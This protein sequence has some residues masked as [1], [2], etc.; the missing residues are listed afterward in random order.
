MTPAL[1]RCLGRDADVPEDVREYF[2][3]AAALNARRNELMQR[4]LARVVGLLNA[5][6]IEPMPLKGAAHLAEGLYPEPSLRLLGDVDILIP[7]NRGADAEAALKAGESKSPAGPPT[8]SPATASSSAD[9]AQ[10]SRNRDWR[11]TAH[12]RH[13]PIARRRDRHGLVPAI[14]AAGGIPRSAHS[15]SRTD[16][17]CRA[18]HFSQR[19]LPRA[20]CAEEGSVAPSSRSGSHT[21]AARE[22]NRLGHAR[23]SLLGGGPGRGA[24]YLSRLRRRTVRPAGTEA[25]PRSP[26]E[27]HGGHARR[28]N[29]ATV[30]TSRSRP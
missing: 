16:P 19:D 22:R 6:D 12:R 13:Q 11:R 8:S 7:S 29:R 2:E 25:E 18:Q 21:S 30:S 24:R 3:A 14:R 20:T 23:P 4:G 27:C 9:P 5:I 28:G 17:Q 10:K 15:A 1:A 26:R